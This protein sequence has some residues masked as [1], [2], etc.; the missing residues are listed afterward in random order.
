MFTNANSSGNKDIYKLIAMKIYKT[1]STDAVTEEQRQVTKSIVLAI[2]YGMG[3][4]EL[5]K[6]LEL[7]IAQATKLKNEF[8]SLFPGVHAFT[9]RITSE[10]SK[11][12]FVVT[13]S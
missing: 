2:C 10:C 13:I 7:S 11:I 1:V 6:R 9:K 12:G 3:Y 5:A 4:Q 8:F